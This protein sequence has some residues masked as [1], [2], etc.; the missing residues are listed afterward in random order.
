MKNTQ[1]IFQKYLSASARG[2]KR[3]DFAHAPVKQVVPATTLRKNKSS[4]FKWIIPVL[5]GS[6]NVEV[7]L[8]LKNKAF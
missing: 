6:I 2:S 8:L 1:K 5:M 4:F 3:E 7:I